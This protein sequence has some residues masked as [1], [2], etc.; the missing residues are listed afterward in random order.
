MQIIDSHN[1]CLLLGLLVPLRLSEALYLHTLGDQTV[2]ELISK[3]RTHASVLYKT[4]EGIAMLDML[5]AFAQLVTSQDYGWYIIAS[6]YT[7]TDS[8]N[9]CDLDSMIRWRFKVD[10]I[11]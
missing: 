11:P 3:I 5:S 7:E 9:K 1:E 6:R 10:D 4:C 8:R 2:Q